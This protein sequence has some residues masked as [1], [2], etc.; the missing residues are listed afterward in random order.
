MVLMLIETPKIWRSIMN[1]YHMSTSTTTNLNIKKKI[2]LTTSFIFF[3]CFS[4]YFHLKISFDLTY[5]LFINFLNLV[6]LNI[7]RC[8]SEFL[9]AYFILINLRKSITAST[10][11]RLRRL[12]KV[13]E[14]WSERKCK[15]SNSHM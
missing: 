11:Y 6:I 13:N 8:L 10:K 15:E 5:P 7:K 4:H 9:W 12:E 2:F 1:I 14:I 3:S